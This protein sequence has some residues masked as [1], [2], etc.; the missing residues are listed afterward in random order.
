M[1][2]RSVANA[3]LARSELSRRLRTLPRATREKDGRCLR[4]RVSVM[5]SIRAGLTARARGP[6]S[7]P[8]LFVRRR[9]A[10]IARDSPYPTVIAARSTE[11]MATLGGGH[12]LALAVESLRLDERARAS[13]ARGSRHGDL[14]AP[15]IAASGTES[16]ETLLFLVEGMRCSDCSAAVAKVLNALARRRARR[17]QPRDDD[18][19]VSSDPQRSGSTLRAQPSQERQGVAPRVPRAPLM[20]A[21]PRKPPSG[22]SSAT[23]RRS[24]GKN[25]VGPAQGPRVSLWLCLITH[26]TARPSAARRPSR[27][28]RTRP[29]PRRRRPAAP[30]AAP[31]AAWRSRAPGEDHAR[32]VQGAH[33][34][35]AEHELAGGRGGVRGVRSVRGRRVGSPSL[36]T[37]AS[38]SATTS[39]RNPCCCSRSSSSGARSSR[40]RA[41][42]R[43]PDP[44]ALSTLLPLDAKLVVADKAEAVDENDEDPMDGDRGSTRPS[45]GRSGARGARRSDP[46]GR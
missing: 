1:F 13:R 23:R 26:T 33:K 9:L 8:S 4:A 22:P 2:Q 40:A 17:G 31:P 16:P 20:R 28:A 6:A 11:W 24:P 5:R 46:R 12:A 3:F 42:A 35:R 32:R 45:R 15:P 30:P 38:R 44:R 25:T 21:G 36:A 39:S 7:V 29:P 18:G 19:R 27:P 41:R 14:A 43:R 34:R 37:T 10:P